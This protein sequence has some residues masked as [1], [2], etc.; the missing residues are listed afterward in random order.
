MKCIFLGTNGWYSTNLGNTSCIL[1]DTEKYYIVLDAGDGI[2]KLNRYMNRTKP[3]KLFLTHFHLDHIIGFHTLSLLNSK[4][5]LE[6]YGYNC[7]KDGLNILRHPYAAPPSDLPIKIEINDLQEGTHNI[8]FTVTCKL[9]LH[10]DPCLGYR[11]ELE[12]KVITYCTDTGPCANL[13]ILAEN[14]DLLITECSF[15]PGQKKWG[16]PHLKPEEAAHVAKQGNVKRLVLTHFDANWYRTMRDRKNAESEA[17]K[18]FED[19]L[20]AYDGL[21]MEL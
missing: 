18:I 16:W 1:I 6:L 14:A 4:K 2:Y 10:S 7:S 11:F 21:E 3:I 5:K 15:K 19:T 20:A 12:D 8:P 17:K 13:N 9:L